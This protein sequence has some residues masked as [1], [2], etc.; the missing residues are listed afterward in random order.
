MKRNFILPSET[1]NYLV[2]DC[3]LEDAKYHNRNK[4]YDVSVL[5]RLMSKT[6]SSLNT[7]YD[8]YLLHPEEIPMSPLAKLKV[9]QDNKLPNISSNRGDSTDILNSISNY[10]TELTDLFTTD[11]EKEK[12][13]L[14]K[15]VLII[16]IHS[17]YTVASPYLSDIF[18]APQKIPQNQ[19]KWSF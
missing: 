5:T 16:V 11:K 12:L 17:I 10:N 2:H 8:S 9:N 15:I 4:I 14:F 7:I 1:S 13:V 18:N 19:R 6:K 3:R